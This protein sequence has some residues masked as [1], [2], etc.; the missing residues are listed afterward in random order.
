ME[1][2]TIGLAQVSLSNLLGTF[3]INGE[4]Q[5]ISQESSEPSVIAKGKILTGLN[6]E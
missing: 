5:F 1:E 2:K 4:Y 6:N 3:E